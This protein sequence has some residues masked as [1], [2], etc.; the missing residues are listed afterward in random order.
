[1]VINFS[2][3]NYPWSS[4]YETAQDFASGGTGER[5]IFRIRTD[6]G[7]PG[8][9]LSEFADT[10]HEFTVLPGMKAKIVKI[11]RD[12]MG[13]YIVDLEEVSVKTKADGLFSAA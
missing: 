8:K 4:S 9:S 1:L 13:R 3:G 7:I 10:E 11:S 2:G 6:K 5:V 12:D